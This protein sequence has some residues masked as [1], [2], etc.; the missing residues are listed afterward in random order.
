MNTKRLFLI[1][2]GWFSFALGV[3]GIFLPVMPTTPFILL[4]AWAFSQSSE[5]FHT[6]L[7]EHRHF[8]PMVRT[9]QHERALQRRVRNRVIFLLWLSLVCSS[10]LTGVIGYWWVAP[11]LA[12]AG[13]CLTIYLMRQRVID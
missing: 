5:R 4:A 12:V 8:G 2:L 11:I 7:L 6:W 13:I 1:G 9:W 10:L 3:I